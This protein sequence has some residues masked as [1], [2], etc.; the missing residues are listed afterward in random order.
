MKEFLINHFWF[1]VLSVGSIVFILVHAYLVHRE[2]ERSEVEQ[3][4]L[5]VSAGQELD[6]VCAEIDMR[7]DCG[8]KRKYKRE[9]KK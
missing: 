1:T 3:G 2:Q 8:P 6:A 7:E 5:F 4:G 9:I